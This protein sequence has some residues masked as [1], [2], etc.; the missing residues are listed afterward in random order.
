M[1]PCYSRD[2][3]VRDGSVGALDE[4]NVATEGGDK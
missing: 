4:E 1:E 2:S 3:T